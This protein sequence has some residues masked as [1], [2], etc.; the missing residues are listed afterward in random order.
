MLAW[1]TSSE[2]GQTR[3]QLLKRG[4]EITISQEVFT[5]GQLWVWICGARVRRVKCKLL[6]CSRP[7]T[8]YHST[9]TKED[10]C[11]YCGLRYAGK[12]Q[13]MAKVEMIQSF[14]PSFNKHVL[15]PLLMPST[16]EGTFFWG[17]RD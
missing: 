6:V 1:K 10:A 4:V 14:V 15:V 5:K 16:M 17:I 13:T 7:C 9:N 12:K 3:N 8:H 2:S 11:L